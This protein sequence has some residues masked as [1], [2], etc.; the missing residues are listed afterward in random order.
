M[1]LPH[2]AP[3]RKPRQFVAPDTLPEFEAAKKY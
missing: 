2:A 1:G 3:D